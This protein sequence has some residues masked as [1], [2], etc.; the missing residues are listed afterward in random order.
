LHFSRPGLDL[1]V[2]FDQ[3]KIGNT[4]LF[5]TIVPSPQMLQREHIG[6]FRLWLNPSTTSYEGAESLHNVGNAIAAG[7]LPVNFLTQ[8]G[9]I[10]GDIDILADAAYK[11]LFRTNKGWISSSANGPNKGAWIDLNFEQRPNW[12]SR[13]QL[14]PDRDM[15][16]Q[17]RVHVDWRLSDTDGQTAKRALELAA[18]EFG[19]LG[20]GRCRIN[21]DFGKDAHWPSNMIASCHHSGTA[22]MADTPTRGVV[23]ANCRVHSVDNLYVAGSAV[24]PTAGY[25]NPT[26]TIVALAQRLAEYLET[27]LI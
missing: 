9:N 23:D 8:L 16:G 27:V 2:Y 11:N 5:A 3:L 18:Q 1:P 14:G 4:Q 25:A 20:L 21:F 15:F 7:H 13:V 12:N 6:G 17:R 10:L 26:L 19:R 22:R 24:F